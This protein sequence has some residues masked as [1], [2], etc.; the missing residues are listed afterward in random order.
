MYYIA[1]VTL[2]EWKMRIVMSVS[3]DYIES[4]SHKMQ[5]K[6][7]KFVTWKEV[8]EEVKEM[9]KTIAED[10]VTGFQGNISRITQGNN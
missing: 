5:E 4:M 2:T 9:L 8:V 10:Y 1:T 6:N 3:I 7:C